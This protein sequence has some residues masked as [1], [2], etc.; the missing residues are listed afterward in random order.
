MSI[1]KPAIQIQNLS[2]Q[3]ENTDT[4][5]IDKL[6]LEIKQRD[7][8]G[9]LGPNGAGK[10]SLISI[11]SGLIQPDSGTVFVDGI[12]LCNKNIG[13]I[14]QR[15]GVV[16]QE[17]ALYPKLTAKE[18]LRFF[19]SMYGVK[20]N[21]L[22]R[23]VDEG[24]DKM[25][26]SK[27][28]NKKINTFSGGMKRRIN[29]LAGLLHRPK[30]LFLDEPTVGVDVQSKRVIIDYLTELNQQGVTIVY[31]SHILHEA[32]DFCS[33]VVVL[34]SGIIQVLGKTKEILISE[35]KVKTLE[36]IFIEHTKKSDV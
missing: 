21:N 9:L 20:K 22:K 11:L 16:P 2:L 4:R 12:K 8:F 6:S 1:L 25:G 5:A 34:D 17:Y 35:G 33:R 30:L 27:F 19:G 10:T 32:Q 29:L 31:S 18:N 24:I 36:E 15:I 23:R 13:E 3:Y 7:I 28:A 26:L 14:R